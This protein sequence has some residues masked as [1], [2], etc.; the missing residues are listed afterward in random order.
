MWKEQ[1]LI[2]LASSGRA[3][4]KQSGEDSDNC[5]HNDKNQQHRA[6]KEPAEKSI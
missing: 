5:Q 3:K 4:E 6:G 1:V 2:V